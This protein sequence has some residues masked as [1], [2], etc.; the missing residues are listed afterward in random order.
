MANRVK[1]YGV[2]ISLADDANTT[3]I[4]RAFADE[5]LAEMYVEI[6]RYVA[7]ARIDGHGMPQFAVCGRGD[8]GL[9]IAQQGGIFGE[10]M[11]HEIYIDFT[12]PTVERITERDVNA[13]M[14][15]A[16]KDAYKAIDKR[17]D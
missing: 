1:A 17:F 2:C 6:F 10:T 14:A 7:M 16:R 8:K 12:R 3:I 9:V 5:G 15:L 4:R 13:I 11:Q